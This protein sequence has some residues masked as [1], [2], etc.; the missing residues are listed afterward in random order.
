MKMSLNSKVTVEYSILSFKLSGFIILPYL[1]EAFSKLREGD[2]LPSHVI[3]A[4]FPNRP[5]SLIFLGGGGD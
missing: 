3:L 2:R 4:I 5:D 1:A